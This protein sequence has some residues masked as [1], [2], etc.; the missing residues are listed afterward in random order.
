MSKPHRAI[1]QCPVSLAKWK[2]CYFC[3]K[4]LEKQKLNLSCCALF[5]MK[6]KVSLKYSVSYCIKKKNWWKDTRLSQKVLIILDGFKSIFTEYSSKT[7]L[8]KTY[9]SWRRFMKYG[10]QSIYLVTKCFMSFRSH[11]RSVEFVI[12]S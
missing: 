12:I 10:L 1:A 11:L 4:S 5:H 3:Q 7:D 6:I 9:I 8:T 2:L